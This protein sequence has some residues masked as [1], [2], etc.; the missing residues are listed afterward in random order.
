MDLLSLKELW[1][2]FVAG[3]EVLFGFR[4]SSAGILALYS[5]LAW[6]EAASPTERRTDRPAWEQAAWRFLRVML[7]VA[8]T[9]LLTYFLLAGGLERDRA[10]TPTRLIFGNF[11]TSLVFWVLTLHAVM[12][13]V[14]S[15]RRRALRGERL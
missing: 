11:F 14:E 12:R 7:A 9:G 10:G 3:P 5:L 1:T 13:R 8:V 15:W 6:W 2:A 4:M